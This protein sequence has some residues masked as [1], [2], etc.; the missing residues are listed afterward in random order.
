MYDGGIYVRQ[1]GKIDLAMS[2]ATGAL[3]LEPG[4]AAIDRLIDQG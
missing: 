1:N 4:E 3:D 2:L